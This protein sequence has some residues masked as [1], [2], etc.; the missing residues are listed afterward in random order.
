[1]ITAPVNDLFIRLKNAAL[2]RKHECVIPYSRLKEEIAK[3]LVKEGY[4]ESIERDA[5]N[6]M[7]R[8]AYLR[9]RPRLTN[10]KNI[11]TPGQRIYKNVRQLK[12]GSSVIGIQVVSTPAGVMTEKE[13]VKKGRGGEVIAEVW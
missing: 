5:G 11:S 8:L 7:V 6:L 2:A 3:V 13:A 10:V 1:M 4:L 9:S 12:K